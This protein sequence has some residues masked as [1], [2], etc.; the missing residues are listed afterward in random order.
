MYIKISDIKVGERIRELNEEKV[1]ELMESI[2]RIGL[3]NWICVTKDRELVSGRHRLEA[4][5]RLGAEEIPCHVREYVLPDDQVLAEIDENFVR[6]DLTVLQKSMYFLQ[7]HN[8]IDRT[9]KIAGLDGQNGVKTNC[10]SF[11][12]VK[13]SP[14]A[15]IISENGKHYDIEKK[16]GLRAEEQYIQIAKNIPENIREIIKD[17]ELVN[18]KNELLELSRMNRNIQKRAALRVKSGKAKNIRQA[19]RDIEDEDRRKKLVTPEDLTAIGKFDVIYADP[20][21][22]YDIKLSHSRDIK[23]KYPVMSLDDIKSLYIPAADEAILFLWVPSGLNLEGLEVMKAW[24]FEFRSEFIW[25]K[26][27]IGMGYW[28][29]AQHE[30]LYIGTKGNFPR[31]PAE[32]LKS[33]VYTSVKG[34]RSNNHSSKPEYFYDL[35]E[36]YF[37][38]RRYLE[39]FARKQRPG[40]AAWG[41][42]VKS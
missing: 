40:W 5:K 11:L 41:N 16:G 24:G 3:Q 13:G 10:N 36:S 18:Q 17:T 38:G 28:L 8:L 19:R 2:K 33:S 29:R 31:P 4:F 39:L 23:H 6:N 35:I 7:R 25:V 34:E 37:P 22:T 27:K 26:E 9:N 20:P 1:G 21:Y 15:G 30:K 32:K 42:E 12:G 14:D